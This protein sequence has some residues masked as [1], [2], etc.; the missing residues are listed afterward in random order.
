[1][2]LPPPLWPGRSG[3]PRGGRSNPGGVDGMPPRPGRGRGPKRGANR[4]AAAEEARQG[5]RALG[6]V[7]G[8][9]T[10][11]VSRT[12]G[13]QGVCHTVGMTYETQS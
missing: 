3:G 10:A 13:H 11:K 9:Q 2:L 1:M 12:A 5:E 8:W 4:A 6:G 7:P